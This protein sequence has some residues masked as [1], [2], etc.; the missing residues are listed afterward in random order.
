[1][2]AAAFKMCCMFSSTSREI[3]SSCTKING[4]EST[5][6]DL[7]TQFSLQTALAQ[8]HTDSNYSEH[9]YCNNI[10]IC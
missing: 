5:G 10:N 9:V 2:S 3:W 8:N 7:T 1:M 4:R 6:I